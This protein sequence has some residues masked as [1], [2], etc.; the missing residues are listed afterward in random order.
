MTIQ[1]TTTKYEGI[2]FRE[3]PTRMFGSRKDRYYSI[4][5]RVDGKRKEEGLAGKAKMTIEIRMA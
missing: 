2:R 1:W 5:Y 4:R 3:H